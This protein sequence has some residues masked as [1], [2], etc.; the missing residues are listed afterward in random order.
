M[1]KKIL[2]KDK[3]EEKRFKMLL[4]VLAV[5]FLSVATL[6]VLTI[7]KKDRGLVVK[8]FDVG[9]GDSILVQTPQNHNILIDGGPNNI[10]ADKINKS[11]PWWD[12]TIDL[13]IL[14]HPHEDHVAGLIDVVDRYKVK[15][16]MYT[17]VV[18][19]SPAYLEW[20]KRIRDKKIPLVLID[21]PQDIKLGDGCDM[22]ILYPNRSFAGQTAKSVN[23]SSIVL[24]LNCEKKTVFLSGD[25]EKEVEEELIRSKIELKADV[26]K[27]SHHGSDTSSTND[28]LKIMQPQYAIISAG[29]DNQF[30]HP[31][32][33]VLNRLANCSIITYRTD[34]DKDIIIE[35]KNGNIKKR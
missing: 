34:I 2:D 9:Q 22:D 31:N 28:L 29:K 16:I 15:R 6:Y 4:A 17:G 20:L 27:V 3:T 7:E 32:Q 12:W 11:L 35:I 14:T 1:V 19:N 23:N 24:L 21:R 10:A 5:I 30:D 18:H 26:Y 8:F 25:I 13:V 33:A